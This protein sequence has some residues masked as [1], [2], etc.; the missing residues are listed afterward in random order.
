MSV[1][2]LPSD[3]LTLLFRL[4]LALLLGATVGAQRQRQHKAAGLRTH[5][6][7]SLGAAIFV[8]IP[9]LVSTSGGDG[10]S[11]TIQGLRRG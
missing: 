9:Q 1:S 11:R 5:M 3:W 8:M 10:V 2:V 6:L 7:V 4:V